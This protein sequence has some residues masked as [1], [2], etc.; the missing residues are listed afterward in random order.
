[1]HK[2]ESNLYTSEEGNEL[3]EI[4]YTADCRGRVWAWVSKMN[5][6]HKAMEAQFKA[7]EAKLNRIYKAG[8]IL[9]T[10][11]A[12][13]TVAV[14]HKQTERAASLERSINAFREACMRLGE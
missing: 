5:H 9:C 2:T 14:P 11:A 13:M 1:M 6:R 4:L 3:T 7:M 10:D 12:Q 8:D